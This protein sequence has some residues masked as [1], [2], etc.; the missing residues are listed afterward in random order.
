MVYLKN[1]VNRGWSPEDATHQ[2]IPEGEKGGFRER[3]IPIIAASQPQIRNQLIP[4]LQK[5]LH[6][7]FPAKWPNFLDL[8][9]QLLNT[10]EASSVFTGLHCLLAIC[11]VY[12][13]KSVEHRKDFDKIV[14]VSFPQLL[15][16]GTGLV[17]ETS[18]EAGEMLRVVMKAYKHATYVWPPEPY[19]CTHVRITLTR[20]SSS[21]PLIFGN[22]AP[23]SAGA[24]SSCRWSVRRRHPTRSPRMWTN[25]N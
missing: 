24:L 4:I 16:I 13:F 6:F 20:P 11:R 17:D 15:A 1:R 7:D 21:F 10:N 19:E 12:R 14:A 3:L 18:N 23:T 8:T 5:I 2:P 25:E 9:L 22:R